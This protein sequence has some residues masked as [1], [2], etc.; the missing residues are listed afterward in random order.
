MMLEALAALIITSF[1][2]A[3]AA[4]AV[5]VTV[6]AALLGVGIS[7]GLSLLAQTFL[8]PKNTARPSDRQFTT[9]GSAT[10]RTR[11]YGRV[12]VGGAQGFLNAKDGYLYRITAH[13]D[14][15]IDAIEEHVIE[16]EPVT[17]GGDGL[18]TDARWLY[19][20]TKIIKIQWRT[21]D[22]DPA[23]Y[24]EL[25]A[26][27]PD[28]TSDH[29]GRGVV[30]S[31]LR[32]QGVPQSAVLDV[33]P[34]VERTSYK[35]TLRGA[36]V[37][38]PRDPAQDAADPETWMWSANA[39][40][41]TLDFLRHWSGFGMPMEWIEPEMAAWIAA[42]NDCDDAIPLKA[43]GTEPRYRIC[44]TYSYDE[45][46]GDILNRFLAAWNAK[47]WLGP[48]GGLSISAGVW[49]EPE[50]AIGDDAI[51][52]YQISSGNERPDTA[53]TISAAYTDPALGYRETD[54]APWVLPDLIAKFGEQR[55]DAKFFEIPSHSQ[56]RRIMKQ[57]A[58]KLAPEWRGSLSCNL[59]A[60]QAL[61][62]RY[63]R[64]VISE[65]DLDFTAEIEN[66]EFEVDAGSIVRGVTIE[67][68]SIDAAAFD[69]DA[70]AEEGQAPE[71]PPDIADGV[72]LPPV[73]FGVVIEARTS[74]A[75]TFAVAVAAWDAVATSVF[76]EVQYK[77]TASAD[78]LSM[79][80]V[81]FGATKTESPQLADAVEYQF[82]ARSTTYA[83]SSDYTATVTRTVTVDPTAPAVPVGLA[84]SLDGS[85]V[86]IDWTNGASAN[87]YGAR[88]YR[89]TSNVPASATLIDTIYGGP[90]AT[91]QDFDVGLAVG[92]YYYW[93]ACING[94]GVESARTAAGSETIV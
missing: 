88:V 1:F 4:T 77:T 13:N 82:R 44:A 78:W 45:R 47:V 38:D 36:R 68:S 91:L 10:P 26:A 66:I 46:P 50:V 53:N 35:V 90:N 18:V 84:T 80:T 7:V 33:Y 52:S 39:A 11:C 21:G 23:Y 20:S 56:C 75:S 3:A 67:F 30:H 93:V 42:A 92:T 40:L 74:G 61:S 83:S 22:N 28:W 54:A 62:E 43:G 37:W 55:S 60:L 58:A 32:L 79:P 14:G 19:G 86:T 27:F 24:A 71:I 41:V 29:L 51:V 6:T 34:N 69:W 63:I 76:V 17:V 65:L 87:T 81:F 2:G 59:L 57:A 12:R 25:G 49:A 5:A 94:S 70:D 85:Q 89:H 8:A 64:V 72:L 73:D 15:P 9:T 16:E 31:L 48:N